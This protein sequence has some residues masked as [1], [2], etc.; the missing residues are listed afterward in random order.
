MRHPDA[1]DYRCNS[2]G[3]RLATIRPVDHAAG[4][5]AIIYGRQ[6]APTDPQLDAWEQMAALWIDCQRCGAEHRHEDG[7]ALYSR[8]SRQAGRTGEPQRPRS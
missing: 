6:V 5:D 4:F 7:L 3:K 8:L 2:C 1:V